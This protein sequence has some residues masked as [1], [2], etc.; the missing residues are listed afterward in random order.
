MGARAGWVALSLALAGAATPAMGH[1]IYA[2]SFEPGQGFPGPLPGQDLWQGTTGPAA[3]RVTNA[4]SYF[5]FHSVVFNAING[6]QAE[7]YRQTAYIQLD[8]IPGWVVLRLEGYF[9]LEGLRPDSTS[10][11]R[12]WSVNEVPGGLLQV[13][14]DNGRVVATSGM[15]N[16]PLLIGPAVPLG[17]WNYLVAEMD[18]YT[19]AVTGMLNDVP[20]GGFQLSIP[21]IEA[22][23][24]STGMSFS[25]SVSGGTGPATERLYMDSLR[26]WHTPAPGVASV[27][28]TALL[29]IHRRRR[30]VARA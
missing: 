29:F 23:E 27:A 11:F 7:A 24:S 16:A 14:I 22:L 4:D 28:A 15:N 3:W 30:F 25:A 21:D 5:G 13:G 17:E 1:I 26:I 6:P 10:S 19:G 8:P 20:F 18:M 2:T 9:K 12:F